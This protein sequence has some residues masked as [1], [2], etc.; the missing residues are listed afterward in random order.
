MC[1]EDRLGGL[2]DDDAFLALNRVVSSTFKGDL[3]EPMQRIW[4]K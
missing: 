2:D 3:E 4:S 1:D